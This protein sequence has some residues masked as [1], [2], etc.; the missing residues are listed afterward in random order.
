[1]QSLRPEQFIAGL[2]HALAVKGH[3]FLPYQLKPFHQ[4]LHQ[5]YRRLRLIA[6]RFG[7]EPGF[8]VS[9]TDGRSLMAVFCLQWALNEDLIAF[10]D[11]L[12]RQ[13]LRYRY[14]T[15]RAHEQL[16][17][18]PGGPELYLVLVDRFLSCYS[19]M[20]QVVTPQPSP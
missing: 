3:T 11:Q 9:I 7:V 6:P 14:H 1:M 16:E 15:D 10:D 18:L 8:T 19:A 2:F 12:L 4:A 5:T 13:N 20:N 17:Q